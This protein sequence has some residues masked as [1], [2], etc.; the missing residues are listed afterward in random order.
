MTTDNF[1]HWLK[2]LLDLQPDLKALDEIQL[3]AIREQMKAVSAERALAHVEP[4]SQWIPL[5]YPVVQPVVVQP[6]APWTPE[7]W[8]RTRVVCNDRTAAGGGLTQLEV[9]TT[10]HWPAS[11]I[12][13]EAS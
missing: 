6:L 1:Y 2:G 8:D 7:W 13:S 4:A 5:P 10:A 11:T 12:R 9:V 3:R